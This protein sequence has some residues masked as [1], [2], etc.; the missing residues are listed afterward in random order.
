MGDNKLLK[1]TLR[2]RLAAFKKKLGR[3]KPDTFREMSPQEDAKRKSPPTNENPP[4]KKVKKRRQQDLSEEEGE[5]LDSEVESNPSSD[6][7][8]EDASDDSW[9]EDI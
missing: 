7:Q 9:S 5:L 3:A 1:I 8:T 6:A 2:S 4:G